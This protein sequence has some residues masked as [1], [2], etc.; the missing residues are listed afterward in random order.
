V[1]EANLG[2]QLS[3]DFP[4]HVNNGQT[5]PSA[6][7]ASSTGGQTLPVGLT[8]AYSLTVPPGQVDKYVFTIAYT[9]ENGVWHQSSS[10]ALVSGG[11]NA[12]VLVSSLYPVGYNA[13]KLAVTSRVF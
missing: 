8:C 13:F 9:R 4:E 5:T 6:I 10:V 2:T 11:S 12:P 1:C 3:R 7:T